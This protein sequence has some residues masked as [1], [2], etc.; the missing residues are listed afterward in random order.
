MNLRMRCSCRH[1]FTLVELLLAALLTAAIAGACISALSSAARARDS[2]AGAAAVSLAAYDTARLIARDIETVVRDS[3]LL[4]TRLVVV[5]GALGG[6]SADE[7]LVLTRTS[8]RVRPW[9]SVGDPA[10]GPRESWSQEVQ[11]RLYPPGREPVPAVAAVSG[12]VFG[13]GRASQVTA[14]ELWRRMDATP[15]VYMDAGG[16]VEPVIGGVVSLSIE[17]SDGVNWFAGWDSDLD[18]YPHMV[19]VT[20]VMTDDRGQRRGVGRAVA[21]IDRVPLPLEAFEIFEEGEEEAAATGGVTQGGGGGAGATGGGGA[22]GGQ[23]GGGRGG[24][25]GGGAGGGRGGAGG[26]GRGAGV[27]GGGQ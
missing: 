5:D 18:G 1:G 14:N 23:G 25:G 3:D 12:G 20:V 2:S 24:A 21:S 19:R 17:A 26:G 16:V 13:G 6:E 15:D 7:V 27:P 4:S 10:A 22:V 11:Y 8:R 9:L